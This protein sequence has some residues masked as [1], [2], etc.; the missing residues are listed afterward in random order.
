M[1]SSVC[2]GSTYR[3]QGFET[4]WNETDS[5]RRFATYSSLPAGTYQLQ[6]QGSNN[7]GVWNTTGTTLKI[8]V[9]PP[10]W[11]TWWFRGSVVLL[12]GGLAFTL[13]QWRIYAIRERNHELRRLVDE[14][15]RA[16]RESER[17]LANLI[18]NLPGVAYRC[19]FEAVWKTTF[20]SKG[21][22]ELTGYEP[23]A[24]LQHGTS[25]TLDS[26]IH[27]DD[28]QSVNKALEQVLQRQQPFAL[29]YR[30][31]DRH[32]NE[33]WVWSQ[34]SGVAGN[35]GQIL[36]IE[37]LLMD[38]SE[39][40]RNEDNIRTLHQA[41]KQSPASVIITDPNGTIEYVNPRFTQITGY[42]F[43]EAWG[44]NPRIWNSNR[45]ICARSSKK[46]WNYWHHAQARKG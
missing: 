24:F 22:V 29:T 5:R 43:E 11:R 31:I 30:I 12:A 18:N 2:A 45:F 27:P 17:T 28:R 9:L 1:A 20:I 7:D 16:L 46:P 21:C 4:Q 41:V 40:K 10:W 36:C 34:G 6:V 14:R 32:G 26:L 19:Q 3:L 35:N 33:K 13:Y 25:V 39:R 23:A 37:G 15:T 44:Q 38:I 42:T 8:T